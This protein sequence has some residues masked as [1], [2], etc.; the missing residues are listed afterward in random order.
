MHLETSTL[1]QTLGWVEDNAHGHVVRRKVATGLGSVTGS[2]VIARGLVDGR[3]GHGLVRPII[4]R[5][6][7]QGHG[8]VGG[9]G[10]TSWLHGVAISD[11]DVGC[12]CGVKD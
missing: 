12:A 1:P 5:P 9:A 3:I 11:V 8:F 2:L 4:C 7:I 10:R 6:V